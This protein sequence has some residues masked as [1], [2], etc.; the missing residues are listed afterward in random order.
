M[1]ATEYI[2]IEETDKERVEWLAQNL[3]DIPATHGR[4]MTEVLG[5]FFRY[6][7]NLQKKYLK[8]LEG[9]GNGGK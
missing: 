3:F 7:P 2:R 8:H 9:K 5:T 4:I 1:A 6:N